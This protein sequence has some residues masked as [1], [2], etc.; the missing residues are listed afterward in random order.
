MMNRWSKR[1]IAMSILLFACGYACAQADAGKD[2]ALCG[3]GS[4]EI[5][6]DTDPSWCYYWEDDKNNKS[7]PNTPKI[8]VNPVETTTYTLTVIGPDFSFKDTD[9]VTVTVVKKITLK[10]VSFLNNVDMRED[11]GPDFPLVH[12]GEGIYPVPVC[13]KGGDFIRLAATINLDEGVS[14]EIKVKLKGTGTNGFNID[15]AEALVF[16]NGT[17]ISLF[18]KDVVKPL[19]NRVDYFYPFEM[20]WEISFDDGATW[21]EAGR[22]ANALY[23]TWKAPSDVYAFHTVVHLSCKS[24]K[25]LSDE[26]GIF[27]S[28]WAEFADRNVSRV[29]GRQ[30]TYYGDWQTNSKA[31]S[32]LLLTG[33]GQGSAW[34]TLFLDMLKIQGIQLPGWYVQ[35][36][37]PSNGGF[38]VKNITFADLGPDAG[39]QFP[40]VNV[41]RNIQPGEHENFYDWIYATVNDA[42][43][44]PA[45]G[46]GNPAALLNNHQFVRFNGRFYDPSYGLE[47]ATVKEMEDNLLGALYTYEF[48]PLREYIYNFDFNADGDKF[49]DIPIWHYKFWKPIPQLVNLTESYFDY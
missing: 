20:V 28:I 49:D 34:A 3:Y 10:E 45:Q 15:P 14:D 29:D 40:Y 21:C 39:K 48:A 7:F 35:L 25:G 18:P 13:Y 36:K 2:K 43:G 30:L 31:T 47:A 27:S 42:V 26:A 9:E 12:S 37:G 5:G 44:I 19:D 8:T 16:T 6:T 41:S 33:D 4:I 24:A 46:N 23:C 38:F 22:S 17:H 11:S 1:N 32:E